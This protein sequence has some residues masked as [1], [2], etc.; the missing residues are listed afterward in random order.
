ME[1]IVEVLR[2]MVQ[3]AR[4]MVKDTYRT[5]EDV[6]NAYTQQNYGKLVVVRKVD[7]IALARLGGG[8]E[9]DES[10]TRSDVRGRVEHLENGFAEYFIEESAMRSFC[11]SMSYGYNDFKRNLAK[12]HAVRLRTTKNLLSGTKGPPMVC[13]VIQ[14]TRK[15]EHDVL[16]EAEA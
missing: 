10:I 3:Q 16:E 8:D 12:T 5:A 2:D 14:I 7:G 9:I 13:K 15:V 4:K 1:A 6:L 11:S